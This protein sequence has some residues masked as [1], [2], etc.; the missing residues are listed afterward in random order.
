MASTEVFFDTNIVAYLFSGDAQKAALSEELIAAGGIVSV[1]VLNECSLVLRRKY[2]ASWPEIETFSRV[3]RA[4]CPVVP[5]TEDVHLRGLVY[6]RQNK[7]HLYDAMIVAAAELAGCTILYSEDMHDGLAI[8][9]VRIHNPY[10]TQ[11]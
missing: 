4:A 1:Q 7:L 6:A 5:L 11:G 2:G 8:G 3:I 10:A 9:H